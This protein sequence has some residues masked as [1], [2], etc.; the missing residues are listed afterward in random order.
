VQ[1]ATV[2][3]AFTAVVAGP[4]TYSAEVLLAVDGAA[5]GLVFNAT[6]IILIIQDILP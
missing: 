1:F 2:L 5:A 6:N 4:H 3:A